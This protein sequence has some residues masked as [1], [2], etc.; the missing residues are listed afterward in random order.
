MDNGLSELADVEAV[1][2][3]FGPSLVHLS[4]RIVSLDLVMIRFLPKCEL[5]VIQSYPF[6]DE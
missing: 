1:L 3:D 4:A 6:G 2:V 5:T